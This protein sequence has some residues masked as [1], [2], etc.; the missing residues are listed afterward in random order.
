MPKGFVVV[1]R[2]LCKGCGL[3]L[4]A[5]PFG[6]LGFSDELNRSG[7]NVATMLHPDK[8][9]GCAVCAQICPDVAIEVYRRDQTPAK[10]TA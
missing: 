9:T 2:E 3:C 10:E 5:C 6:V 4:T 7:Y 8:C 1:N